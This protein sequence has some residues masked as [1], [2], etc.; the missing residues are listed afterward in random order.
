MATVRNPAPARS[1]VRE[2]GPKGRCGGTRA[3]GRGPAELDPLR[4]R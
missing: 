4:P 3:E 1:T 2:A